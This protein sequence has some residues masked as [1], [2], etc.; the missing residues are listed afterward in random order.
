MCIHSF[1]HRSVHNWKHVKCVCVCVGVYRGNLLSRCSILCHSGALTLPCTVNWL[2]SAC[3]RTTDSIYVLRAILCH[4]QQLEPCERWKWDNQLH[5]FTSLSGQKCPW[6]CRW[7]VGVQLQSKFKIQICSSTS[8]T[9]HKS[10]RQNDI[11]TLADV[12]CTR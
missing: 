9:H 1:S 10:M 8:E 2:T 5:S 6:G 7:T 4:A 11:I 3:V 12:K